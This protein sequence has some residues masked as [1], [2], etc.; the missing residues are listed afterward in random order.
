M[1]ITIFILKSKELFIFLSGRTDVTSQFFPF[2]SFGNWF[3]NN[4]NSKK[5]INKGV[6]SKLKCD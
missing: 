2:S 4:K 5:N 1:D 3:P 6:E